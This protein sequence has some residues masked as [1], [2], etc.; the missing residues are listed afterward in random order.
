MKTILHFEFGSEEQGMGKIY[1]AAEDVYSCLNDAER[2]ISSHLKTYEDKM[3][4]RE[5]K[6]LEELR[7]DLLYVSSA[8]SS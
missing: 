4:A 1:L 6:F 7:S 8:V 3:D 2:R 5:Q